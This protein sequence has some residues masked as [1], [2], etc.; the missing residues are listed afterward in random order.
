MASRGTA[1]DAAAAKARI[2]KHMNNDHHD[3]VVRYLQH[4]GKISS[5]RAYNGQV[6]DIDL[7]ALSLSCSGTT[8][9]VPFEPPMSSLREARERVVEL[10]RECR[11]ALGQSDV[12]VKAYVPPTGSHALPFLGALVTFVA[13]SQRWWF[14]KGQFVEHLLGSS[15]AKFSWSIQPWLLIG[16]AAIHGIEMVYFSLRKLPKHSV[17]ARSLQWWLWNASIFIEGVFAWKRFDE[18]V[19]WQR[20]KQ[21]H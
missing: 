16:L 11:Q 18:H 3:S 21:Q 14:E 19:H 20:E 17:N 10:D 5:W 13:Y 2:I 9:R 6:A 1:P 15:F 12:T 8:V 7:N 4:Y